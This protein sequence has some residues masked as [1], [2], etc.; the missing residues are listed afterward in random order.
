MFLFSSS[1]S[2]LLSQQARSSSTSSREGSQ[3]VRSGRHI[4][5][6]KAC[7]RGGFPVEHALGMKGPDVVDLAPGCVCHRH[8]HQG[9]LSL[10]HPPHLHFKK[11]RKNPAPYRQPGRH[12]LGAANASEVLVIADSPRSQEG[13]LNK[14]A[15]YDRA[16][17]RLSSSLKDSP[18]PIPPT[19]VFL[20]PLSLHG[21]VCVRLDHGLI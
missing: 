11:K 2:W 18:L 19:H 9:L 6:A 10:H 3:F 7:V 14:T 8:G 21:G 16:Q 4:G 20:I 5:R 1:S 13:L 15:P 12:S 17:H